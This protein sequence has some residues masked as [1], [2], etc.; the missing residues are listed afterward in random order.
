MRVKICAL[1]ALV[2]LLGIG[3]P[4]LLKAA[5]SDKGDKTVKDGS[6][7]S[8]QYT[9]TGEDGKTIE[10][11]KGKEPLKYTQG[12]HQIVPGLERELAGMKVGAEKHVKVKPEDGYG[13]V[14]PNAFQEVP[15]EQVPA[16]GL[17]VGAVLA[18]RGPQGQVIPV[19]IHQIKD[20][21][22]VVDLNHP[23]AGK[24]LVFDVKVLDIQSAP[25]APPAPQ[26]P[27]TPAAPA[28]PAKPAQPAVPNQPA[29]PK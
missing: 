28:S 23:M 15:K 3:T 13:P 19:R 9:L 2:G 11:N 18:A 26:S 21:T 17:K 1:A 22:V 27:A 10:S 24:T 7:V 12:R 5:Q 6:V 25:P 20:K 4:T 16:E 29:T 8:L 14:N